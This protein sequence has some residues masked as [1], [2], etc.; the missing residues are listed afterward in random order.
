M[1]WRNLYKPVSVGIIWPNPQANGLP[2][3]LNTTPAVRW[4]AMPLPRYIPTL[5]FSILPSATTATVARCSRENS[6]VHSSTPL[7]SIARSWRC[8][9][10]NL[11]TRLSKV[12]VERLRLKAT[13]RNILKL[14][15]RAGKRFR[16]SYWKRAR[17]ARRERK[18]SS[19]AHVT[20]NWTSRMKKCSSAILIWRGNT[21]VS[22]SM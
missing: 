5:S 2:P 16:S 15:V 17:A 13:A 6:I 20:R 11:D 10:G 4:M 21:A 8:D 9:C 12:S 19:T 1:S 14:P 22:R 18:S 7:P 3:G